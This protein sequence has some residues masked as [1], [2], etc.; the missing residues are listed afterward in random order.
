V[1]PAWRFLN[2]DFPN[3]Y[4]VARLFREGYSLDRV[5]D[6][7]WL[8][9]IKDH[10]GLAQPLVGFAGL[11]PL[12]ALPIVPLTIFSALAAKRIW[13]LINLGL[14]VG[15]VEFLF[16]STTLSRRRIWLIALLA[17]LPLRTSFLYGQ[18]HI[19]VLFL[20][21]LAYFLLR[22]QRA[23]MC[24]LCIAIAAAL[25]V[26][27]LLFIL[28]FLWR[29]QWRPA[30]AT[31]G[32]T[33][34]IVIVG[35]FAMGWQLLRTY[36]LQMLP[37]TL[38][39]EVL[40]PYSAHAASAAALFHRLFL[41]EPSLN[42]A[43]AFSSPSLYAVVYPLWQ[44]AVFLPLLWL[45]YPA[46][47]NNEREPREWAAFLF[48][49]LLLSPVPSSYHFVVMILPVVLFVDASLRRNKTV[50]AG[51]VILFYF[52]IAI[53]GAVGSI[54]A[55]GA[56]FNTIFAFSRLWFEI[57]LFLV[58]LA[59]LFRDRPAERA[60]TLY[61]RY[62]LLLIFAICGLGGSIAGYRHHFLDR[63]RE[64]ARRILPPAPT[65]LA[66]LP[67]P[68]ADDNLFVAMETTGYRIASKTGRTQNNFSQASD[69]LSFAVAKDYPLFVELADASGSRIVR[70]AD[71]SVVAEDAET[72]FLSMDGNQLGFLREARGRSSLWITSLSAQ[73]STP[74][75][76]AGEDYDVRGAAFLRSGKILFVAK[77]NGVDDFYT[78]AQG[79][80]PL[81]FFSPSGEVSSF[82]PSP[83]ERSLVFTE[84][85]HNRW[86]LALL[87]LSSRHVEVLTSTDCNAYTPAWSAPSSIVY[88]TDC[89]RGVGLTALA[90][91]QV[92]RSE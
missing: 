50:L 72:P 56:G 69:E 17:I 14:L 62:A 30:I 9:R 71:G 75:L 20:M 86:Q 35:G 28:Y 10:W 52:L 27:P 23:W 59:D 85:I 92:P 22:R 32:S 82:A 8:Q 45:L 73:P 68:I 65:L 61:L 13:I 55:L 33:V 2:T 7:I 49:L 67:Q 11:T 78:E 79:A 26:Y 44:M 84:L 6:W 41:F 91:I 36:A 16:R 81:P 80:T 43:P 12:S 89:G 83:D 87:D 57:A 24:G 63:Q 74:S 70:S 4:L 18:M 60:T 31:I 3:Y 53:A 25:K 1:I 47:Q 66:A 39:G 76:V 77:R 88:A 42:P 21:T 64:M 38:Q 51:V 19:A 40:D 5:Y 37:R 48:S 54:P 15:S 46:D 29:R 58:F 34:L 90:S